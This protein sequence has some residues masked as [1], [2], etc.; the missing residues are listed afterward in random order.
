VIC[1][2]E[3]DTEPCIC[4]RAT[5]AI[6]V[7]SEFITVASMIETV[8]ATRFLASCWVTMAAASRP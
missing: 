5:L 1:S 4:G 8:I 6:V 3:A 7:S 2:G